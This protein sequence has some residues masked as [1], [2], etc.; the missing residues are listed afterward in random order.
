MLALLSMLTGGL[1]RLVP[2]LMKFFTVKADHKHELAMM[3]KQMELQQL[4][5]VGVQARIDADEML[6]VLSAQSAAMTGQMQKTGFAFVDALN[7]LVRPLTT[8]YFLA[9]YGIVK[10]AMIFVAM[11]ATDPWV[12]II[13]CW[14]DYDASTLSGILA[15]WFV[16]RCFDKAAK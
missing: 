7:F 2:E 13:S 12:S 9:C 3:D 14:D 11:R 10:T 8:Y 5:Q 1:L 15:F 6:A 16:G 4:A